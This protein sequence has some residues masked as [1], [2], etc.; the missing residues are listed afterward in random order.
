MSPERFV[1]GGSERTSLIALPLNSWCLC[2][3]LQCGATSVKAELIAMRICLRSLCLRGFW[4]RHRE[5]AISR[6]QV[7]ERA[8]L[9][10]TAIEKGGKNWEGKRDCLGTH[11][12]QSPLSLS[13]LS[14]E[15]EYLRHCGT[16]RCGQD[17]LCP[18][19]PAELR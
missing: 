5:T 8:A 13:T 18:R 19:I 11:R 9:S 15:S 6:A 3:W 2:W 1:K 14:Y 12:E 10:P 4:S 16:E 17:D 7:V